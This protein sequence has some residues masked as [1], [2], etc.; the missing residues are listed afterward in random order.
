MYLGEWRRFLAALLLV[1]GIVLSPLR[2]VAMTIPMFIAYDAAVRPTATTADGRQGAVRSETEHARAACDDAA[3]T[4][5]DSSNPPVTAGAGAVRAY[6]DA[7]NLADRREAREGTIYGAPAP[8]AEED[9]AASLKPYGGPGGGHHVPAKS[10][11]VGAPGYDANA[12]LAIPNAE[13]ARLGVAHS[14]VT[15][16]QASAYSAFAQTGATLTWDVV[17]KIE[18]GALVRGGMQ[19]N[20]AAAT[21]EKAISA[22]QGAGIAGPTRI[23]W[24]G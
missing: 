1:V 9:E 2:A 24:G 17:R 20:M 5:D 10:A 7:P 22:L 6:D 4:Y 18:I 13:L 14:A 3:F 16:A 15:G 12:A 23:P 8:I 21:V 11:F 19:P